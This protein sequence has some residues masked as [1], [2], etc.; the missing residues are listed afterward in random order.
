MIGRISRVH[1][2]RPNRLEGIVST[3]L[4]SQIEVLESPDGVHF[5]LPPPAGSWSDARHEVCVTSDGKLRW[6]TGSDPAPAANEV[7]VADLG[8]FVVGSFGPLA[9]LAVETRQGTT[10]AVCTGYPHDW[11]G[12]LAS[13]LSR[14]CRV[15][16]GPASGPSPAAPLQ[17]PALPR[18]LPDA[19]ACRQMGEAMRA[20]YEEV[21]TAGVAEFQEEPDQPPSSRVIYQA[22]DDGVTLMVPPGGIGLFF[23]LGC[24]LCLFAALPTLACLLSGFRTADGSYGPLVIVVIFWA[25]ALAVFLPAYHNA[26]AQVVLAVVGDDLELLESSLVHTRRRCWNRAELAGVCCGDTGWVSGSDESNLRP[27]AELHILPK[28]EKKVGLA[29]RDTAEVRWIATVLRRALRLPH[30]DS[31]PEAGTS[32]G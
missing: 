21:Q 20:L 30:S 1:P 29:G 13:E 15:P 12:A 18:T 19:A 5:R 27:V 32:R 28:D 25:I 9:V 26:R 2:P 14:H 6:Q 16:T 7:A 8:Q 22:H 23:P 4:P 31:V 24:G 10:H 17:A 11:L 3:T